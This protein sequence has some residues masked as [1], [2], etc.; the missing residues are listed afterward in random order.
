M[1]DV[2]V[3]H[4]TF[5]SQELG[6]RLNHKWSFVEIARGKVRIHDEHIADID[7][8]GA[9]V[10]L[11]PVG[12]RESVRWVAWAIQDICP[13]AEAS[14]DEAEPARIVEQPMTVEELV[15]MTHGLVNARHAAIAKAADPEGRATEAV[16]LITYLQRRGWLEL[17]G[18]PAAVARAVFPLLQQIDGTIGTQ[19]EDVLLDLD[20]VDELFADADQL[21]KVIHNNEHIFGN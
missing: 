21:A 2:I 17:C 13:G 10:T 4:V 6:L 15:A 20:E 19:L 5:S 7:K 16:A 12:A 14:D 9:R 1:S 11:K 3:S 8:R 18:S